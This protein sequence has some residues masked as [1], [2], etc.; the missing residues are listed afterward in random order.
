MVSKYWIYALSVLSILIAVARFNLA[1]WS[2]MAINIYKSMVHIYIG[3][4]IGYWWA[5]KDIY[6]GYSALLLSVLEVIAFFS[7]R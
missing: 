6:F 2:P 1:D 3:G 5:T 4:F 7:L